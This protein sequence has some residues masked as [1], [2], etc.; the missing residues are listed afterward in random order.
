[1]LRRGIVGSFFF[2][3][4]DGERYRAML[5]EFLFTKIEEEDIGNISFQQDSATCHTAEATLDVLRPVFEDRI[6][7]RRTDDVWPPRSCDLKPLDYYFWLAVK[8]KCYAGKPQTIDA[9]KDNIR[10]AIG[11]I[12]LH[13]IDNVC[14]GCW[15]SSIIGQTVNGDR[16]RTVLNDI[17]FTK[18]EEE[19][20][21]NSWFHRTALRATQPKLHSMFCAL[22]LKIALSAAELMSFGHLG[23]GI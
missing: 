19:D 5:K 11:E 13:T 20:I 22:L 12:Q 23:A 1:M 9:F 18:I 3:D 14:Y 10:E 7:S 4:V 2:E 8:D 6:I 21:G 17:L 15:S 16:Y